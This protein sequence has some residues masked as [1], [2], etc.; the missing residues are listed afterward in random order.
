[1]VHIFW[2]FCAAIWTL[3]NRPSRG[4]ALLD[5][6]R[7]KVSSCQSMDEWYNFYPIWLPLFGSWYL[8]LRILQ[9]PSPLSYYQDSRRSNISVIYRPTSTDRVCVINY[10]RYLFCYHVEPGQ[11]YA[12]HGYSNHGRLL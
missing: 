5:Y 6:K 11:Q 2:V 1:M 4:A 7:R 9:T 8:S 10:C 3:Y 12:Q